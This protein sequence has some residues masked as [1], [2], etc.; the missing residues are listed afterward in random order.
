MTSSLCTDHTS[1]KYSAHFLRPPHE[2][3]RSQNSKT[4]RIPVFIDPKRLLRR[5]CRYIMSHWRSSCNE[6]VW[7]GAQLPLK[8]LRDKWQNLNTTRLE[9]VSFR[10]TFSVAIWDS[11]LWHVAWVVSGCQSLPSLQRI[12]NRE[13]TTS[14]PHL[15]LIRTIIG[16]Q[17]TLK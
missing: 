7:S 1:Q 10:S 4:Q 2:I 11:V 13:M 3:A 12:M 6:L 15:L 9:S 14:D 8:P 5:L 17:W 16:S